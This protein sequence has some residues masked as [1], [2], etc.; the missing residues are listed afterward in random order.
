MHWHEKKPR[1]KKPTGYT[2]AKLAAWGVP[3]PPPR[4]WKRKLVAAG[5]IPEGPDVPVEHAPYD[6]F[7]A[8]WVTP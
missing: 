8:I 5:V 6:P 7:A 4:G 3:W 1:V 2:K